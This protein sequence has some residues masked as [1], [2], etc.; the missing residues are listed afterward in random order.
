MESK[1]VKISFPEQNAVFYKEASTN[2][3]ALLGIDCCGV[4]GSKEKLIDCNTCHRISYCSKPHQAQDK[5]VHSRVCP[6]L[7]TI[8]EDESLG[9]DE[10]KLENMISMIDLNE[11]GNSWSDLL[12]VKLDSPVTRLISSFLSYPLTLI[13]V[14]ER[15]Y[16]DDI[17]VIH[18]IGASKQEIKFLDTWNPLFKL[19]PKLILYFIGPELDQNV[20]IET[21]NDGRIFIHGLKYH[22]LIAQKKKMRVPDLIVGFHLGLTVEDYEW[23]ESLE[24]IKSYG[25]PVL[26]TGYSRDEI[27]MDYCEFEP[28]GY[29][30]RQ[31]PRENAFASL[32]IEQSG[33]LANDIYKKNFYYMLMS[34]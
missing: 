14:I 17:R 23:N 20:K 6:Y 26:L 34:K 11:Y 32:Q 3:D 12:K 24:A 7:A 31:E 30:I 27:L 9:V 4:C 13:S 8:T 28:L 33:T 29:V 21:E 16:L 10:S 1:K 2:Q 18:V 19:F 15:H 22:E 25:S 5:S